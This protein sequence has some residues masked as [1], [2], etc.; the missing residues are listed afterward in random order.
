MI[1]FTNC[2]NPPD[3]HHQKRSH[4]LC[5]FGECPSCKQICNK[6]RDMCSHL[7]SAPCH[8]SVLVKM[9]T[10][11]ATMPWEQTGPQLEKKCLPCPD[12]LVPVPVTCLGGH[13]TS[14]WPCY[15]SR[16]SSCHRPCG[17]ILLCSN[18]LCNKL[19]HLVLDAADDTK[20]Y[21][22]NLLKNCLNSTNM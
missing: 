1:L 12:C 22:K 3:C 7:C 17:R 15:N 18:H 6:N 21:T 9:Q 19:C 10:P 4:H 8:S 13:E 11:K 20:V 16:V 5:H 14:E 2:R